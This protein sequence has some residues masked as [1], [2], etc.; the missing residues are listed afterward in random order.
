MKDIVFTGVRVHGLQVT[1]S[2]EDGVFGGQFKC[3]TNNGT[4]G[5][6]VRFD[7]VI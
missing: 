2:N 1:V 6:I 7:G 4:M 3:F 5:A